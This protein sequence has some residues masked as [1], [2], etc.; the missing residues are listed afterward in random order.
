MIPQLQVDDN[1]SLHI[2]VDEISLFGVRNACLVLSVSPNS[3]DLA[4]MKLPCVYLCR[5]FDPDFIVFVEQSLFSI[6]AIIGGLSAMAMNDSIGRK[7][8]IMISSIPSTAGFLMMAVAKEKSL[9][10]CGRLFTGI[11][12]GITSSSVPVGTFLYFSIQNS[13]RVI[14]SDCGACY[15]TLHN[16]CITRKKAFKC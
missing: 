3:P 5:K 11:S 10:Y 6:G 15:V 2:D 7:L 8:S 12:A 1:P 9:L 16:L 4:K 14:K 13:R